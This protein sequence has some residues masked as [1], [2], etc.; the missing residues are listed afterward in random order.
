MSMKVE[1]L[2]LLSA[3][4]CCHEQYVQQDISWLKPKIITAPPLYIM[5]VQLMDHWRKWV[6]VKSVHI[7][8]ET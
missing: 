7:K 1:C 3:G 2:L 4:F 5:Y 8:R 6:N